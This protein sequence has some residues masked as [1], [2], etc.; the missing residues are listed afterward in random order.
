MT[1]LNLTNVLLFSLLVS[2][3]SATC[4]CSVGSG[5]ISCREPNSLT[6]FPEDLINQCPEYINDPEK[7]IGIIVHNQEHLTELKPESFVLFPN[8]VSIGFGFN[9]LQRIHNGAF[10][11]L[12]SLNSLYLNGNNI[13]VID[14][15]ALDD[16]TMVKDIE[17][18]ENPLEM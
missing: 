1:S 15:G 6:N 12:K 8:L 16:L 10:K 4:P 14:D 5:I 3:I 17:L 7:I 9:Y 11:D 2:S 13:T 18:S